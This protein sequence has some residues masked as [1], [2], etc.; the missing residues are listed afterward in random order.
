MNWTLIVAIVGVVLGA[1]SFAWQVHSRLTDRA[2]RLEV[3]IETL[4]IEHAFGSADGIEVIAVN[5]GAHPV[6]VDDVRIVT[7]DGSL[8]ADQYHYTRQDLPGEIAAKGKAC[9]RSALDELK[10][11]GIDYSRPIRAE[12]RIVV[13]KKPIVSDWYLV[14]PISFTLSRWRQ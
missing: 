6:H 5:R 13:G 12:L 4:K 7:P 14:D 10:S 9:S 8:P 2:I 1:G 11:A 3:S